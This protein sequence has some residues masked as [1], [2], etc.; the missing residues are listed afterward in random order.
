M[1][2]IILLIFLLISLAG[3]VFIVAK[4]IPFLVNLP[5]KSL[6]SLPRESLLLRLKSRAKNLPAAETIHY[7]IYLQK[8]LSRV[9]IITLKVEQK[10]AYWLEKL[11]QKSYQKRKNRPPK[12]N[13]WQE[14]EKVKKRK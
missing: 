7:E 10:I 1:L 2:E 14:L 8:I 12:D 9:R 13:Y 3:M 11:R 5:V 6:P 4:K